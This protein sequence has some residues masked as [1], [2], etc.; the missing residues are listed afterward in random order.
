M[1][2]E[3]S[4]LTLAAAIAV[5]ASLL[6]AAPALADDAGPVGIGAARTAWNRGIFTVTA[7]TDAP[8]A[9]V[10]SV[11]A[12]VR[13]GDTVVAEV[14]AL[15]RTGSTWEVPADAALKLVE[16]GGTMPHLGAYAIDVS[17][18]DDQG[19]TTTRSEAGT[20]DF[21]LTPALI[22]ADGAERLEFTRLPT[23]DRRSLGATDRLVGIEPGTGDRVPIEGRTVEVTRAYDGG[24]PRPDDT[25]TAVTDAEGRFTTEDLDL[26]NWANFTARFTE[27]SGQVH[28]KAT[29]FGRPSIS[30]TKVSV[31][32][33]A[34]LTRVLPG[35]KVTVTGTVSTGGGPDTAG[36]AGIPVRVNLRYFGRDSQ[37]LTATTDATGHFS[38]V[39]NPPAG[40]GVDG[41]S[42]GPADMYLSATP[43][44]GSLVVP[45][46]SLLRKVKSSIAAS[47]LVKVT[48]QLQRA[49]SDDSTDAESV[50]LEYSADGRTGWKSLT[51]A[52]SGYY[53]DFTLSAWGYVDGYY[54]VHHLT[55]DRLAESTTAPVRLTRVNTRMYSLKASSTKVKKGT[56][57]T[58]TGALKEYV[59]GTWRPYKGRHVELFFQ[60]KGSTKWTYVA[61]GTTSSTGT[62]TLKGK[63][64]A[65]GKWLIQY[66][67]DATHF[68]SDGTAVYVDVR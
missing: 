62:A 65:D 51:T 42:V 5:V 8:G 36:L 20:L 32:A 49:Y 14:P 53:G 23:Y 56:G 13:A 6:T 26:A 58:F 19:H 33:T 35:Q 24:R 57:V 37:A 61:S 45:E 28:G 40:L 9:A 66:F 31:T 27:D 12:R 29:A 38:A 55:S 15:T 2:A 39:L 48:G 63:P 25:F 21:T 59:S 68:D 67:G 47:G 16:D 7:W 10:T 54:R 11:S 3:R 17:A 18:T 60:K 34:D 64:T 43:A 46:E 41:W 1:P 44:T 50:R 22:D 30:P 4:S 52:K